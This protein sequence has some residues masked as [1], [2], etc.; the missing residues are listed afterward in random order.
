MKRIAVL[1]STGSI[2]TS[3]LDIV[4]Q[5]PSNF[6][7][8]ALATN[9]NIGL[10][11]RQIR[12]FN[13]RFVC[14][15]DRKGSLVL[16][17]KFDSKLKIF[18]GENEL[19]KMLEYERIDRVMLSIT[20][21]AALL[22]L[23]KAI[24]CGK[25]VALANKEALVMAGA[26]VMDNARKKGVKIIPVDSEQSAI[27]QCLEGQDKTKLKTIYLTASGGPFR[28]L[29]KKQFKNISVKEA[30]SHP[31]WKMG[32]KIT[33]DSATLLNKGL[34]ILEAMYLFGVTADK[35]KV[36]IHPESIIH[37]MVEFVDGTVIAQLSVTDMRV[38]IQYALLYPERLSSNRAGIDF[39]KLRQLNFEKPDF[40]KFPCL[41][42]AYRAAYAAGTMPAVLNAA[43]EV[44]VGAFLRSDLTFV[45]IPKVIE[46]VM[47]C[48]QNKPA[49]DLGDILDADKWARQ[50]AVKV[51]GKYK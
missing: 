7:A 1:G 49:P 22:P 44:S 50:E 31:R 3:T 27:W 8:V 48:H 14:V 2:G 37:S 33:V 35:I 38:P 13:P 15:N 10:L 45:A 5:F 17:S 6:K 32:E 36:V 12:E 29:S 41:S 39:F 16:K 30:L 28:T 51:M 21:A 25:D 9:S 18:S 43:N 42:L 26:I 4:R 46:K 40:R 24:E 47:D 19:L 23:L 34:E 11:S 20:G